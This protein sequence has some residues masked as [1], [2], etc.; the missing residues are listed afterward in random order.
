MKI[1][2]EIPPLE[3]I[4]STSSDAIHICLW[5]VNHEFK[6]TIAY[7]YRHK[8]FY[9]LK[10]VED[11]PLDPRVDWK[12]FRKLIKRGFKECRKIIQR[13]EDDS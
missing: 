7:F 8:D 10:F 3:L 1:I 6:W 2:K 9:D 4:H 12:A 13:E 11:R 5:D